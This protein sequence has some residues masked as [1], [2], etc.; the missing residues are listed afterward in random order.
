[1]ERR[2]MVVESQVERRTN[3]MMSVCSLVAPGVS[4]AGRTALAPSVWV[5]GSGHSLSV[6]SYYR[7]QHYRPTTGMNQEKWFHSDPNSTARQ[8]HKKK[9]ETEII[10]STQIDTSRSHSQSLNNHMSIIFQNLTS[11]LVKEYL[12]QIFDRYGYF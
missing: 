5:G 8:T 1:M 10:P 11:Q 7:Q 3:M 12:Y 9:G 6:L 2:N 4:Q